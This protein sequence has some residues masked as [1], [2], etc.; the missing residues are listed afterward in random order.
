MALSMQQ[1]MRQT[2][3]LIMTPQMQ[4][5]IQLLQMNSMDL[6]Q[7]I[8]NEMLENPFLEVADDLEQLESGPSTVEGSDAP[9]FP[10]APESGLSEQAA[11]D[12]AMGDEDF[13]EGPEATLDRIAAAPPDGSGVE[14][15]AAG[16]ESAEFETFSQND[17]D[18]ESQYDDSDT[19]KTASIAEDPDEERDFTEYT[20]LQEGLYESLRRQL[21]LSSLRGAELAV[22][23][24]LVGNLNEDGY[25]DC[26]PENLAL[27][28]RVPVE[29]VRPELAGPAEAVD[30]RLRRALARM[31]GGVDPAAYE[32]MKRKELILRCLSYLTKTQY[33][34]AA[35]GGKDLLLRRMIAVRMGLD[36]DA[37]DTVAREEL[38]LE[39]V[40]FRMKTTPETVFDV[41]EVVQEFE[42]TG[43]GARNL[44][45]CLRLQCE[46]KG[47]RT[48]LLYRI[49][50]ESLD[51]LLQ[52]KFRDL[53][54]LYATSEEEVG[55]V[56]NEVSRLEPRPGRS[57]S[58]EIPR[59]IVPDVYVK[60]VDGRYLYFLNEGDAGRLVV[61][62]TYRRLVK[63]EANTDA[64]GRPVME[65]VDLPAAPEVVKLD[66]EFAHAKLKSAVWLIKNIE[67]RKSTILRVTEAIMEYQKGFLE[68]GIES[69]RPLT[70]RDIAEV[71]GMHESTIARVTSNKFVETPRGVFPL[72]YFFNS[73]LETD[74]GDMAASRSIK[75]II[76]QLIG[77]ENPK[78]PLS[79]QKIADKLKDKGIQ[80]ARRTVAKYREQLKILPARLRKEVKAG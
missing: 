23:E 62:S 3:R 47:I 66:P 35:R 50:E 64:E 69:L 63:G 67:K 9:E 5:S 59:T 75:E 19:I 33:D 73:G 30:R 42:P 17:V 45:E 57:K 77:A 12:P 18:W 53:A 14:A 7:M 55:R 60:K 15:S 56:F 32:T 65:D 26:S 58:K 40:A 4:Q 25:L 49:L 46:E 74:E 16:E 37:L 61:P 22:G 48:R 44:A 34:E 80:I 21:S 51:L 36:R 71:V 78:R 39:V 31:H 13:S 11:P 24:F 2:Q 29:Y 54:K 20:A 52:K 43:V 72:K 76:T 8:R 41:L 38:L 27:M 6:E 10:A 28:M 70:L 68:K 1:S 79:D